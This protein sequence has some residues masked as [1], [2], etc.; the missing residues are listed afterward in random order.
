MEGVVTHRHVAAITPA[1][2]RDRGR[3]RGGGGADRDVAGDG[4]GRRAYCTVLTAIVLAGFGVIRLLVGRS[5]TLHRSPGR[6][7]R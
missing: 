2:R 5:A 1:D 3:G 4:G 7:E 6:Q